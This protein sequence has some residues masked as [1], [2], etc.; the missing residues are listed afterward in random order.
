MEQGQGGAMNPPEPPVIPPPLPPPVRRRPSIVLKVLIIGALILL[1]HIPIYLEHDVLTERQRYQRQAV[2]EI[3]GIWGGSQL[4]IGPVLAVPYAFKTQVVR[5][6]VVNGRAVQVEETD[7]AAA[8][9]HFLPETL[10]VEGKVDPEVRHRGIYDAVVYSTKLSLTGHLLPDFVA[11]GIDADRIDWEKA[12]VLFGVSDLRGVRSVAPFQVAGGKASPFEPADS[13]TGGF[14]PLFARIDTAA[15]GVRLEFAFETTLQG[16]ERLQI[17][18]VG[19]TTNV[20][21][22]STWADPSF[23]GAYLP[24]SR[25]VAPD[26]F[27]AEWQTAH[28]S[29]GFPQSWTSRLTNQQEMSQ[30]INAASFGVTFAQPMDGYR[31][32]ERAEKYALLILVLVF[33]VFFLFEITAALPIHPF[34]YGLV[35]AALCLFFLGFLSLT[36]FW[37]TG[38]AY[39]AAAAVCTVLVSLYAWSFLRT[40]RRTL[41]IAGGLGATY[42]YLYFVLQSQ[43]YALVA[44]TIALFAVLALVMFCTRRINWYDLELSRAANAEPAK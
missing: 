24:A 5:S 35:G 10:A 15:A 29:R 1:L 20:K 41:I 39:G 40:G 44:G 23:C 31:L 8:T 28:F 18:P 22:S 43:D 17:A 19:K 21:I 4:V 16:S 13:A 30:K 12:Y 38:R 36:E 26:G 2:G 6:R 11:A 27:R 37:A 7:F 33:A 14:L 9:A 42:G 32:V 25:V 3:T 34:Q